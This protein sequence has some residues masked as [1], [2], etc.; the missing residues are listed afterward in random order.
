MSTTTPAGS[1]GKAILVALAA[2]VLLAVTVA[3]SSA[4]PAAAVQDPER[5]ATTPTGWHF[6]VGMTKTK[7]N[8]LANQAHERVV[9]VNI[10]STSPLR[11]SAVLV[12]NAGPYA[13][14]GGWSF[15]TE[16]YVTNTINSE[17]ARLI[18]LE[19]VNY[20]GKRYF[21]FAWVRNSGDAGKGWHWN[22]D[23]SVKGVTKE[24]NKYK[25]RLIDLDTY[26]VG[27]KRRYSYI[28]IANQGVDARAWWWYVN[29]T[30]AFVQQQAQAHGARL[31]AIERPKAGLMSVVMVRNDEGAYS[32]HVYDYTQTDL[33]HFAA[34]NAV[35][36]TDLER[37][38]KNGKARFA[39]TLID[40]AT[41]ENRRLRSLWRSSTMANAPNGTDAWFGMYAKEVGGSTD[42]ALADALPYQPLSVL[43]LIPHLY[44]MDLLDK[45]PGLDLLDQP[46]GITWRA[47]KGKPDEIWCRFADKGKKTQVYSETLRKTLTRGL[48]ESLNR[49]HEAL[50]NKYHSGAINA[51]VHALGLTHTNV[52]PGC[53]QPAGR[54]DWTYNRSTLREL[55]Q[56]FENVDNRTYFK[57]N[58]SNVMGEF[59]GL[60]ANWDTTGIKNVVTSEAAQAGKPRIVTAFMSRVTIDGKGGG[61][62]LPQSDGTYNGGRGFFGR[63]QLPFRTG[64]R[65]QT[66]VIKTFVGGYFV[67]NFK[68][69]CNE[70]TAASSP[71]QAC[72]DW[73]TKQNA[74]YTL[75]SGEPYRLAI[76]RAIATWPRA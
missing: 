31:I 53:K 24:I 28:G 66:T 44:V 43:K 18:D 29:V 71:D 73:K 30:P 63:V 62:L 20:L 23:L 76:R 57:N 19:P 67:D 74:T 49:A 61:T 37:Y 12:R 4:S 8:T 32:R 75:F 16:A 59:Y 51:R 35:R 7:I 55:G 10:D 26:V 21:A 45:D 52:Y 3:S 46:K 38:S 36:I 60:M 65:A 13:R 14:T 72:R 68:A 27:G 40:N 9:D 33:L 42:V 2:F 34:S 39:A 15:G 70:D 48:G 54:K 69:P 58:W 6:W 64:P 25:V 41:P 11:Y 1:L 47:L 56:L 17:H 22:Y 5:N 50:L